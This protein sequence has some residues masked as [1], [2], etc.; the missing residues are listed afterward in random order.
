[1]KST[2]DLIASAPI[3]PNSFHEELEY[4]INNEGLFNDTSVDHNLTL[5]PEISVL[6]LPMSKLNSTHVLLLLNVDGMILNVS[7]NAL[8]SIPLILI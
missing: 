7:L 6:S 2:L 5:S 3:T 4:S 8:S 1:M